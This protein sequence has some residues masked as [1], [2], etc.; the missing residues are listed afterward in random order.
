MVENTDRRAEVAWMGAQVEQY[1]RLFP[2]YQ[3]LADVLRSILEQAALRYAP[4]AIVQARPKAIVSFVEKI[5]RKKAQHRDPVNQFTDLCGGRVITHTPDEVDAMCEFVEKHFEIDWENS[6]DVSQRLKPTEF[7]YRS[8]HYI[9]SF[10]PGIFS[11]AE[12]DI[13]IPGDVYGLK[14]EIQVR[15]ILEHAW[16]D[17][18]HRLIYKSPFS[19][20][21]RWTRELAGLAALLER[22]DGAFAV[23]ESGLRTYQASYGAYLSAREIN[24]EI[25]LLEG[26]L[27]YD[28]HNLALVHRVGKLAMAVG[29]W[30]KAVSIFSRYVEA[31]YQPILRDLGITLCKLHRDAPTGAEYRQGQHYLELASAFPNRDADALASLAGTW[32]GVDDARARELYRQAFEADP[33]EPYPLGRYLEYQ[34]TEAQSIT[35]IPMLKRVIEAAIQRCRDRAEVGMDLP[36]PYYDMGK[37]YLFLSKPYESL[38]AYTKAVQLTNHPWMLTSSLTSLDALSTAQQ[39][40]PGLAWA[41]RF[42]QIAYAARFADDAQRPANLKT[43]AVSGQSTFVG[44]VVIIA[45]AC[46]ANLEAQMQSY[47]PVML[48]AFRDFRGT[49]I[50]GGTRAGVAGLAGDVQ[51]AYPAPVYAIGYVPRQLSADVT[52]D[53][54]YGELRVTEGTDFSP[55]EPIQYWSDI[56]AAG[57]R[58]VD[59]K[60]IAISGGKIAAI[61]YRIALALGASVAVLAQSGRAADRLLADKEWAIPGKLAHLPPDG[62]ILGAFVRPEAA[63]APWPTVMMREQVAAALH[64]ENCCTEA[65]F[66][67]AADPTLAA[68]PALTDDQRE[69]VRMQADLIFMKLACI[70]YTI[71]P[72]VEGVA[73]EPDG[74]SFTESEATTLAQMEHAHWVVKHLQCGWTAGEQR[75][76]IQK[77]SPYLVPWGELPPMVQDEKRAQERRLPA[78][79]ASLGFQLHRIP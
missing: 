52:L 69:T 54:R 78:L 28:S 72:S 75:D 61:E 26:V 30:S 12:I 32:R 58:P 50:S 53:P 63:V 43:L 3:A 4:N 49:V 34:V 79:L 38:T 2:R 35:A 11:Q 25:T 66:F 77:A 9:V 6:I 62:E 64:G 7:G 59:V 68:W 36:W 29:D 17:F 55:L 27:L 44:P 67:Q 60:L 39:Q 31:G 18:N 37:F 46:D 41:H 13:V 42:L 51:Q 21:A 47:R 5:Q 57:I 24:D 76:P 15:T 10:K 45:G 19:V 65:A 70:G 20:P 73:L 14:A 8:V 48:Q 74:P 22:A 23:I 71:R 56:L 40:L 16:A 33:A 1:Q